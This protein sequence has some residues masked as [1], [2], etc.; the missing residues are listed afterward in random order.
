[1]LISVKCA[2][3]GG[4]NSIQNKS[5]T[6]HRLLNYAHFFINLGANASLVYLDK[7][8]WNIY[9]R[10]NFGRGAVKDLSVRW[11]VMEVAM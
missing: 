1:M 2:G 7:C 8:G 9:A 3:K 6:R 11:L 5:S 10:R 4:G